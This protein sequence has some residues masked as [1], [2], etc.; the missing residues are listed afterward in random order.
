MLAIPLADKIRVRVLPQ[1]ARSTLLVVAD[2]DTPLRRCEIE[3]LGPDA[4]RSMPLEVGQIV[5]CNIL[6]GQGFGDSI[7]LPSKSV[8]AFMA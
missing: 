1:E 6:N 4:C 5:L 7:V 2:R 3:A 8:V